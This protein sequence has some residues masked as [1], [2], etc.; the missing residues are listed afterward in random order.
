MMPFLKIL[1]LLPSLKTDRV[2]EEEAKC[3][4]HD[5]LQ[6]VADAI[7]ILVPV[8][9]NRQNDL[10]AHESILRILVHSGQTT[11]RPICLS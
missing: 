10:G 2:I 1:N 9:Q 8:C 4:L 3:R 5:M 6:D 11:A 7:P